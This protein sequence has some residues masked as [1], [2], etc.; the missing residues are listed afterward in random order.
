V[1]RDAVRYFFFDADRSD[2]LR[3][4]I[5]MP[6]VRREEN[7]VFYGQMAPADLTGDLPGR[8]PGRRERDSGGRGSRRVDEPE[9]L[10]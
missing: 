3:R 9:E 8:S 5:D 7:T 1:G 4:D 6:S 2:P 10:D